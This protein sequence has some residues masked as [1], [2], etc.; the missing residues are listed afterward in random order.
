ML[1]PWIIE[2]MRKERRRREELRRHRERPFLELEI[3]L[4]DPREEE[5]DVA[6]EEESERGVIIIEL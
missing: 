6:R 3:P 1:D 5:A 2:E 4:M